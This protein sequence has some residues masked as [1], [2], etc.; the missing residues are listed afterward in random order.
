MKPLFS[1][2]REAAVFAAV[3][4]ICLVASTASS[5]R[6][7]QATIQQ[8]NERWIGARCRTR[9]PLVAKKAEDGWTRC[10]W[11]FYGDG[12]N[13]RVR[14]LLSDGAAVH[15]AYPRGTIP[16]GTSWTVRGWAEDDGDLYLELEMER[17]P[18]RARVFYYDDW[19]GRV[20]A[21]RLDDFELWAK[22]ELLEVVSL[23]GEQLVDVST[24]RDSVAASPVRTPR[25]PAA[26]PPPA[27][28]PNAPSIRVLSVAVQP[29][30]VLAGAETQLIIHYEV[31]GIPSGSAFEVLESRTI[32]HQGHRIAAFDAP[33]RRANGSYPSHQPLRVPR[34]TDPGVYTLTARVSMAG[35]DSSGAAVFEVLRP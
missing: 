12:G 27:V 2:L 18:V 19:V 9:V 28:A 5:S 6:D 29:A 24:E 31:S 11:L 22:F 30:R 33:V 13:E 35:R 25:P 10:K 3:A 4:T 15:R 8:A 23:P 34:Q 26:P 20:G 1:Q 16:A 17:P 7:E 14:V 32:H 21:R